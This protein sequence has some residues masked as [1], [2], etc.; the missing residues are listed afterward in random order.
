MSCLPFGQKMVPDLLELCSIALW[1]I[2]ACN[3]L[4]RWVIWLKEF[5]NRIIIH[6]PPHN[7]IKLQRVT[8]DSCQQVYLWKFIGNYPVQNWIIAS[9]WMHTN[10]YLWWIVRAT[11]VLIFENTYSMNLETGPTFTLPTVFWRVGATGSGSE[12]NCG[13][14]DRQA[15]E[16]GEES[17]NSGGQVV[18]IHSRTLV[19][20]KLPEKLCLRTA[21]MEPSCHSPLFAGFLVEPWCHQVSPADN[22]TGDWEWS[23]WS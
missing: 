7:S 3:F 1:S 21:G 22:S 17:S 10:W 18:L 6:Q 11:I 13:A 19:K 4:N 8:I 2:P 14:V 20:A 5:Q 23:H 9:R 16:N 12:A 15:G